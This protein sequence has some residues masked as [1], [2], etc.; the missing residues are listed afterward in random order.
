MLPEFSRLFFGSFS[1]SFSRKTG[2]AEKSS[3]SWDFQCFVFVSYCFRYYFGLILS[4]SVPFFPRKTSFVCRPF[5]FWSVLLRILRSDF[6]RYVSSWAA[7][8]IC[9]PM[10]CYE[11]NVLLVVVLEGKML[12]EFFAGVFREFLRHFFA[13]DRFGKKS[14]FSWDF[15]CFVFVT[16]CFRYYFGLIWSLSV[17]FFPRKT[18]LVCRPCRFT[19]LCSIFSIQIFVVASRLGPPVLLRCSMGIPR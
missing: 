18:S 11:W 1:G 19:A 4:L 5:H 17:P 14:S 10:D 3:F 7:F 16:Y 2:S 9:T 8:Y 12:P 13:E 6:C 15:Q